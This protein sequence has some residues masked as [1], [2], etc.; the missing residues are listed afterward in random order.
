MK[1]DD[2]ALTR[3]LGELAVA[4]QDESSDIRPLLQRVVPTFH[5]HEA[6]T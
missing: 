2:A 1:L 5:P 6:N 3:D 4:L